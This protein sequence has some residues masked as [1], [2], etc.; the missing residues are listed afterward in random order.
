MDSLIST[1]VV[2]D[3]STTLLVQNALLNDVDNYIIDEHQQKVLLAGDGDEERIDSIESWGFGRAIDSKG[4]TSL[5]QGGSVEAPARNESLTIPGLSPTLRKTEYYFTRS[6]PRY[7]DLSGCELVDVRAWGA[8]GDGQSDDTAILN[9]IFSAAANMSAVVYI[10][11]GVYLVKDTVTIPVGSRVIGQ[12]WPQLM[13]TGEKFE[14]LSHPRPVVRVG[15]P[16]NQGVAEIQSILFTVR[17][18]TA[19]AVLL[20]WNVH[21]SFQGSA[22]LWGKNSDHIV[23]LKY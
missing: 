16:G 7:G 4:A 18:P 17:G 11:Y 13:G 21:E 10:P 8:K 5:S 14:D 12:A 19:G 1:S 9:Y 22:G 20:E 2:A 23:P 3:N 6:R 15:V